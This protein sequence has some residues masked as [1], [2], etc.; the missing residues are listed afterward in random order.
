MAPNEIKAGPGKMRLQINNG[1]L[2]E[3]VTPPSDQAC[4]IYT[5]RVVQKREL[6]SSN[7]HHDSS[8]SCRIG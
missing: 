6:L 7:I 3:V 1:P 5:E 8:P 2:Q 4:L